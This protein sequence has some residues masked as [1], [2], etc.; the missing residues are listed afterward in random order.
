MSSEAS[1]RRALGSLM[2]ISSFLALIGSLIRLIGNGGIDYEF[3][4]VCLIVLVWGLD[5]ISLGGK[6]RS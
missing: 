3:L 2:F 4:V 6:L 1:L 5:N